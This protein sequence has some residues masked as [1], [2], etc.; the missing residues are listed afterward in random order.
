MQLYNSP[1]RPIKKVG[2]TVPQNVGGTVP[3][4]SETGGKRHGKSMK[5]K[6]RTTSKA[7]VTIA[8]AKDALSVDSE[9]IYNPVTK[10]LEYRR[11]V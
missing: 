7:W 8:Q 9:A 1:M 5:R 11:E 4:W 10:C 6:E 3:G 2:Q